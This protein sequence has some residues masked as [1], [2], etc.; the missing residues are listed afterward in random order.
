MK[1]MHWMTCFLGAALAA[2]PGDHSHTINAGELKRHY[3]V[4]VPS[5]YDGRTPVPVVVMLHGGGGTSRAAA[6]E[7][8]WGAKADKE[9]FL[10][11]FPD[12]MARDPSKPG[13]FA[14]NPQLWNDGSDRFYPGQKAPDDVAFL[15][16]MLDELS[17]KFNVDARR[18]YVT[19]FSNGAS[20]SFRFGAE[21]SK[22]IAAIAP[23][24]GACWLEKVR[25]ERPVPMCYL[26]GS[27]DP[28]NLIEGGVPRL[29]GGG[30]DKVRAKPKPPVRD[31][32]RKWTDALGC[33][34]TPT[35]A[36]ETNG[37]HIERYGADVV[38]VT[39]AGQ[40]HTWAG[41]RSLLPGFMVGK[42][43]DKLNAT[44]FIW[45]FFRTKQTRTH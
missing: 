25:L 10:A 12:A 31:S 16:A 32:I 3:T 17:A 11:V 1:T 18:I 27:A 39:V 9:G 43:T 23:V 41:G 7:T 14:R 40:G 22:R 4:H 8:G 15:N 44:D 35:S 19:G 21:A 34:A 37:V 28:L 36:T 5:G 2:N 29:L 24:A 6:T 38:Y 20:M 13:S 33:S 26:T 30:S 45:E 42:T